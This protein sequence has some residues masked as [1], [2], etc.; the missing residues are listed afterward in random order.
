MRKKRTISNSATKAFLVAA[1]ALGAIGSTAISAGA[2]PAKSA[3][4]HEQQTKRVVYQGVAIQVPLQW[5]VF[6]LR[7]NPETC[8]RLDRNAVYLGHPAAD[9]K[10]SARAVGEKAE[11]VILENFDEATVLESVHVVRMKQGAKAPTDLAPDSDRQAYLAIEGAG[12]LAT[13]SYAKDDRATAAVLA[14]IT[15]TSDAVPREFAE[16]SQPPRRQIATAA[17]STAYEGKAFD[18]CTAP[19]SST[20]SKWLASP[21]RAVGIY[22]GGPLRACQQPN[23]TADWVD[24]QAAA[25]WSFLPIYVGLQAN[26][27][28]SATAQAQGRTAGDAAVGQAAALGFG[29]GAVVYLDIERFEDNAL[30]ARVLDYVAGWTARVHER[31]YR[32]GVYA[33]RNNVVPDLEARYDDSGYPRP[34]VLWT[35]NWDNQANVSNSS[36]G[37]DSTAHW[38]SARAHQYQGDF[39]ATYG[40]ATISI[41]ANYLE[42]GADGQPGQVGPR[43]EV[44]A[45]FDGDGKA[46][47]VSVDS[48]SGALSFR[49]GSGSGSTFVSPVSMWG[50]NSWAD[51]RDLVAAD[52][53]GDGRVDIAAVSSTGWLRFYG[54][55]G[56][57]SLRSGVSMWGD[58]GWSGLSDLTAADFDSDGKADIVARGDDGVLRVWP[59]IGNGALRESVRLW[60]DSGWTGEHDLV[61]AD[62]DGDGKADIVARGDDGGL[63]IW[64]G[65]GNN[66]LNESAR[67]WHDNGFT[68]YRD[69]A[70]ADVDN[71]GTADVVAIDNDGV[72]RFYSGNGDASLNE[73]VR[74]QDVSG[75]RSGLGA[76]WADFSGDGKADLVAIDSGGTLWMYAGKGNGALAGS[77]RRLWSDSAWAGM[78]DLAAGDFNGDGKSDLVARGD[79]GVLRIWTGNGN[80][81]LNESV[82]LWPDAAWTGEQDIVAGDFN[83][84]GKSDLVARGDD[85]VLRIWTGNGNLSLNEAVHLWPDA[86]WD[87]ER[88]L[89]AGD[90]NGDGNTDLVARGLDGMLRLWT[91]NGN[92][93]LNEAAHMWPDNGWNGMHD[94]AAADLNQDGKLD[95]TAIGDDHVLRFYAGNGDGTLDINNLD[96][97]KNTW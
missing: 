14:S 72:V 75:W 69:L 35:A 51:L 89:T 45:D 3:Q 16:P 60:P 78:T 4:A 49:A 62:F 81:T 61:A 9:Q 20:M 19:S 66:S 47:M 96:I 17:P 59:G 38:A 55:N 54:G 11:A 63:R 91:G 15:T 26:V 90:F 18:T 28:D 22:V 50:D 56:D 1:I 41:D 6:D 40:G 42:V 29:P 32:S 92:N 97:G 13:A 48:V 31:G 83:G 12:V 58:A 94:L 77:A 36:M 71:N 87:G 84:D 8:V 67:I 21:Y 30:R 34:D 53:D 37:L 39:S 43:D 68:E 2:L 79:D 88:D 25:G 73:G 65:N 85:G 5:P 80:S 93:T 70:A 57:G 27:I 24:R 82:W 95:V 86:A 52:F 46:D 7:Q 23:L 76:V 74:T 44:S 10:C 33:A 64:T